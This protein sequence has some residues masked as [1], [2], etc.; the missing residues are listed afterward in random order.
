MGTVAAPAASAEAGTGSV[1]RR[2]VFTGTVRDEQ[3]AADTRLFPQFMPSPLPGQSPVASRG[4][5]T[6]RAATWLSRLGDYLQKTVEVTSWT[7]HGSTGLPGPWQG[8][9][10]QTP[11]ARPSLPPTSMMIS[12]GEDRPPSSS[13]SAGISPE[14]VQAEVAKQV[15]MAMGDLHEQLRQE[16]ER[17]SEAIQEAQ[18]LRRQL[19][20]HETRMAV[21][22]KQQAAPSLPPPPGL[23]Q[24]ESTGTGVYTGVTS[25]H[26][27]LVLEPSGPRPRRDDVPGGEDLMRGLGATVQPGGPQG[28]YQGLDYEISG[29]GVSGVTA[30]HP[31]TGPTT[32]MP[33][34]KMRTRSQSPGPRAFLQGLFGMGG[35][36]KQDRPDEPH[37]GGPSIS[38]QG[39]HEAPVPQLQG[40]VSDGT[41]ENNLLTSM[42][43]GIEALLRQQ[44]QMGPRAD[45][46][47]T[48][49]PGIT[50]LPRLPEYQP[51]TGSI[52]LLNWLTHIQP[53]MEDLSDTSAA[54]WE[55]TLQD[56]SRWYASYSAA[57]PLERLRLTPL[58]TPSLHRPEWARV[59]RRA[60]AMMLSAVPAQVREEAIAMGNVGSLTLLCKLYAVYQPGNLQEKALVLQKLE[61]PD[62]CDTAL[63]AV[64]SLRKWTLW[65][66]RASS[67][68]I[69]EPDASVLIQGL[70]R[71]TTKVVKANSEL[72]FRVSLIR[73]TL[74][75]DV[76]PS[77][78]SVTSFHQHL[79]A[80]MEQ[81]A[82]LNVTQGPGSGTPGLRA[83][84]PAITS[85]DAAAP[86]SS[87]TPGS[88][89]KSFVT[90]LCKFFQS[91]KGCRRGNTCRFPHTWSL[92]EKGARAKK[93][94]ACGA[95]SHKVK[96]CRAPGGGA[97]KQGAQ[98]S[99]TT[100]VGE[101]GS[102][103]PTASSPGAA[104]RKVNF[105]DDGVIQ[106][107][108][109]QVLA[110]VQHMPMFKALV[111]C[112][113]DWVSPDQS[114]LPVLGRPCW[115]RGLH[116][117]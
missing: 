79:Q 111:D 42:A 19:D 89:P 57:S 90:A 115:I 44:E 63:Q 72:S 49:K 100:G 11:T 91:E 51:M 29:A 87:T 4:A 25:S 43:R 45:R 81:Q 70:D 76:C 95:T 62:E 26:P 5:T 20:V 106:S 113:R 84:T 22:N 97:A 77:L 48:V 65:R 36:G 66:R 108:V 117:F 71:I 112:V 34:P 13:G 38:M 41:S 74:Q 59:E 54:W 16:R 53:I 18:Q 1:P 32:A 102:T 105:E 47:E 107:K 23:Q 80:E 99:S 94:L 88:S 86:P 75:V 114:V 82:R 61:R 93:C 101:T 12:P 58:S 8:R 28:V 73:S 37:K 27:P 55:G 50:D 40:N 14:L 17:T 68:G 21:E 85:G 33:L 46:P 15:Q 24:I 104:Q 110:E 92:L 78:Q 67:I 83:V 3:V 2:N 56:A 7:A 109:L 39:G 52:D 30:S 98:R 103:S 9:E 69:A 116:M 10:S 60:T 31:P 96:E 6:T 64:E 35:A